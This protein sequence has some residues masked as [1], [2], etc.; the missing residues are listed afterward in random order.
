MS[1]QNTIS[2]QNNDTEKLPKNP[3]QQIVINDRKSLSITAVDDVK[4]FDEKNIIVS[5]AFGMICIDGKDLHIIGLSVESGELFIEG[6]I[7]GVLF[8]DPTVEK[9]KRGLFK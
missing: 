5:T 3:S 6:E 7:G 2:K 9:R 8:F 4:S 1:T